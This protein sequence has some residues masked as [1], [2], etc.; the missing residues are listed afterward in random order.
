M[1]TEFFKRSATE[2]TLSVVS[3]IDVSQLHYRKADGRNVDE[4]NVVCA[5]FDRDGVYVDGVSKTV[6]LRLLEDT[7]RNRAGGAVPIRCDF[8]VAPGTYAI[9]FVARD[10][11]GEMMTA[12]NGA[13]EIPR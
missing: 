10:L 3:R 4:I 7:L 13:V 1:A 8:K 12:Q 6:S 11:E 9:R 5:L 2:A